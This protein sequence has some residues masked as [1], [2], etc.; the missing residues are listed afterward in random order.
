MIYLATPYTHPDP[1]MKERRYEQACA[2]WHYFWS[3]G[4]VIYS[5]IVH[6]RPTAK[7]YQ[8]P[9]GYQTFQKW[10]EGM[11]EVATAVWVGMIP[12]YQESTGVN[13]ETTFA[14][15]L[16]LPVVELESTEEILRQYRLWDT[17]ETSYSSVL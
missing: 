4:T 16:Q 3:R 2:L 15:S 1:A 8:I 10:D 17:R 13:N 9:G 6:A 7:R 5:P 11:I 14:R 12:G